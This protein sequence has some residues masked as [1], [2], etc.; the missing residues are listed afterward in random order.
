MRVLG[1]DVDET[2]MREA[3]AVLSAGWFDSEHVRKAV[4]NS[5]PHVRGADRYWW[6]CEVQNRLCQKWRREGRVVYR[7]GL[8]WLVAA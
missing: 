1:W 5:A 8:G 7:P 2:I 3:E 4:F 6:A